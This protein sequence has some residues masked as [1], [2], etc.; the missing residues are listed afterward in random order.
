[1]R[2][3][4]GQWGGLRITPPSRMPHTRP[5]TDIARESLFNI[6]HHAI[7]LEGIR[8]LDLF[9]G[10][11]LISFELA[12]RG[13]QDLTL[14]EKDPRL[15]AFI[16]KTAQR[17][18]I[19]GLEAVPRDAF[20]FLRQA[21]DPYDLIFADPP[22]RMETLPELPGLVFQHQLLKPGGWFVLEHTNDQ[23]FESFPFFS[24]KRNYGT[25]IFSIFIFQQPAE[26]DAPNMPV[27]RKF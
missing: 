19:T 15:V 1:M 6:L 5:T 16:R 4:G 26:N 22:Y 12:S 8:T 17:I 20:A 18:G 21:R 9:A 7:S 10:T 23:H 2:I 27:S 3:I 14:V 24:A 11:G 25:T 13:A